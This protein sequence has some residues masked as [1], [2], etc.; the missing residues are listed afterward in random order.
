MEQHHCR[1]ILT[2][3]GKS[4]NVDD[5]RFSFLDLYL[6]RHLILRRVEFA[7]CGLSFSLEGHRDRAGQGLDLSL[8]PGE[9]RLVYLA[10]SADE[11]DHVDVSGIL[12]FRIDE[13]S[14]E[15]VSGIDQIIAAQRV[16]CDRLKRFG[17]GCDN[18]RIIRFRYYDTYSVEFHMELFFCE[19]EVVSCETCIGVEHPGIVLEVVRSVVCSGAD[20]VRLLRISVIVPDLEERSGDLSLSDRYRVVIRLCP[21]R[22]D[23]EHCVISVNDEDIVRQFIKRF[24]SV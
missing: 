24:N 3:V 16:E 6:F 12:V 11:L 9:R 21:G 8:V 7:A 19:V 1:L 23:S 15:S 14:R 20:E 13:F 22:V 10:E 5:V 17:S 18:F 4:E 2:L